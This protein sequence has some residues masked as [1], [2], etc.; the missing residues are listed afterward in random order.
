V[1]KTQSCVWVGYLFGA[2]I[3]RG[4]NAGIGMCPYSN[5]KR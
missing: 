1:G 2:A 4:V 5:R 3:V